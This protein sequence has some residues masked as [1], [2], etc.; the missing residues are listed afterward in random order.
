MWCALGVV[1]LSARTGLPNCTRQVRAGMSRFGSVR[2]GLHSAGTVTLVFS[3]GSIFLRSRC[4]R[5]NYPLTGKAPRMRR[6][7]AL[8]TGPKPAR[9]RSSRLREEPKHSPMC[10]AG[11]GTPHQGR[12]FLQQRP[13]KLAKVLHAFPA[14]AAVPPPCSRPREGK[15][16]SNV[17]LARDPG[18]RY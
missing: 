8:T 10:Q 3:W 16:V 11:A 17:V 14:P 1:V 5:Q 6:A 15:D 9:P 2:V 12:R 13:I 7:K 4:I 18:A